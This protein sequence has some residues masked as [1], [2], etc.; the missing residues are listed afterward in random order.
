V[1]PHYISGFIVETKGGCD[2]T[3]EGTT[4]ETASGKYS[5]KIVNRSKKAS[6]VTANIQ[7][8][9]GVEPNTTYVY[10][11]KVKGKNVNNTWFIKEWDFDNT[12]RFIQSSDD[13]QEYSVEFTT[14]KLMGDNET[15]VQII[16]EDI[17]DELY[18]DDI[19]VVKK[20]TQENL[21]YDG[22]FET[23]LRELTP[24][25]KEV[26]EHGFAVNYFG[27]NKLRRY[28]GTAEQNNISVDICLTF[29][30][31][32]DS[33]MINTDPDAKAYYGRYMGFD[34]MNETVKTLHKLW[35][36]V[37]GEVIN[38]YDS[39]GS[40]CILNEPQLYPYTS[41]AYIPRW[42]TYLKNKYGT[43]EKLNE[44]YEASYKSIEEV[45]MPNHIEYTARF[46]DYRNFNE[47]VMT[48]FQEFLAKEVKAA[49]P[50]KL[51]H[52]KIMTFIRQDYYTL[53]GC[54]VD[55]E[56]L[57]DLYEINGC[58]ISIHYKNGNTPLSSGMAW[59]D[60]MTSIAD[61]PVFVGN[62]TVIK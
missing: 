27:I 51:I 26:K 59:I 10:G 21:L 39:V 58:D 22:G 54:G 56:R 50:D 12:R 55:P 36:K 11:F 13:W 1:L 9:V 8:R 28:L 48:E 38:E 44:V 42:H 24:V 34:P 29:N 60:Y 61:K 15:F 25:E 7:Q 3:I 47:D 17:V 53:L 31:F 23:S 41:E 40:I 37:M 52:S 30:Y 46:Y 49:C 14:P 19:C 20:G 62:N 43:V 18:I 33:Q 2:A 5:L 32:E 57:G 4:E 6:G 16:S 45:Q 35:V